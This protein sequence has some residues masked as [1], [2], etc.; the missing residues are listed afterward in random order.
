MRFEFDKAKSRSVKQ[1]HGVSLEQA[2]EILDQAYLVDQK[3]DDPEQFRAVGWCGGRICSEEPVEDAEPR[4]CR[5]RTPPDLFLDG[6]QRL[7]NGQNQFVVLLKIHPEIGAGAE[8]PRQ[9]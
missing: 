5:N 7:L 6:L 2:Q 8:V 4:S 1:K 9:A 3:N